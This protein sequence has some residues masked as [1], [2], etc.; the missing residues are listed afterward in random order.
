[1]IH[2]VVRA[3]T[4]SGVLALSQYSCLFMF[5]FKLFVN[6]YITCF[7]KRSLMGLGRLDE[8]GEFGTGA[9]TASLRSYGA[10]SKAR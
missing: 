10:K 4:Y 5:A 3:A 8:E 1:M 2:F 7:R 9:E 6:V